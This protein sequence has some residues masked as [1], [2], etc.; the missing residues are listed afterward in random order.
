M[1]FSLNDQQRALTQAAQQFAQQNMA[2]FAAQWDE[3]HYF[4]LDVIQEAGKQ[5]Y[6][7]LYAPEHAGG[8]G[9]PRLDAALVFEQLSKGCT[10]TAAYITIHNMVTWMLGTYLPPEEVSNWVPQLA[11]GQ[12]LGAYCLTEPNAGSDAASLTTRAQVKA[13]TVVINGRKCFISGGGVADVMVVMARTDDTLSGAGGISAFLVPKDTP[14]VSFGKP[15]RKLGWRAQPTCDVV[16][17][18]VSIP[19]RFLLGEKG[20]GFK[21]AMKAL[22]GGRVN[23][24]AC[25]LG[26]AENAFSVARRYCRER[27]QFHQHLDQFQ[28]TQFMLADMATDLAASKLM[29]YRAAASLD[30][31]ASDAT[32]WCAMAKRFATDQCYTVCDQAL[33]LHGGYGYIQDYP[34]E[35][36]LRDLRVH[37]ILEGTNE[38]MRLVIARELLKAV[39]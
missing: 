5:G 17:E 15:E 16:F 13:D 23:I 21:I 30:E 32:Q 34:V 33:Q 12:K 11:Q 9:L 7:G 22:D 8:L 24:A 29:V 39:I 35:R 19:K 28:N 6:C 31:Q 27:K 10:T 38:I 4:P 2:P 37:R 26:T 18:Q 36:Y 25:A 14:G 3:Q 1:D 20:Q